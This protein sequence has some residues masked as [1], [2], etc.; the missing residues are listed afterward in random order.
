MQVVEIIGQEVAPLQSLPGPHGL[1]DIYT[2]CMFTLTTERQNKPR[3]SSG[4]DG[5]ALHGAADSQLT[6]TSFCSDRNS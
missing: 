4:S 2:H 5:G 3:Q 6:R 1:I